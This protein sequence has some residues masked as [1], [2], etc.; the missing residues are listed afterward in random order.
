KEYLGKQL[1]VFSMDYRDYPEPCLCLTTNTKYK[2][3]FGQR[4][5][6]KLEWQDWITIEDD[7]ELLPFIKESKNIFDICN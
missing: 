4:M 6:G 2:E 3:Y 7:R 5:S 1:I